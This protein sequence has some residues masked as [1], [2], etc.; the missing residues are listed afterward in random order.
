LCVNATTSLSD[1]VPGGVW[2]SDNLSVATISAS[3]IVSGV[4]GGTAN[5]SYTLGTCAAGVAI[6]VNSLPPITGTPNVCAGMMT[7][8]SDTAPGG[9]WSSGN[10][11]AAT[12]S[13][14]GVVTGIVSGSAT[15]YYTVG[16][17]FVS[18][19]V[20]V[21]YPVAAIT[22]P[23]TVCS[24][25]ALSLSDATSGGVW[26]CD[27]TSVA[28]LSGSGNV[29][30]IA[31]GVVNISYTFGGCAASTSLTVLATNAGTIT[32]KD[33]VC[34]GS[35]HVITLSDAVTGGVWTSSN[36][37]RATV[38][39]VTG[40]VTGVST[41][42]DTIKYTVSNSCGTH[43]AKFVLHVRTA[44][45]CALG[46]DQVSEAPVGGLKLFPD[47]N[48]GI[49]TIELLA[50]IDEEAFVTITNV[51][52][53]KVKEFTTNTNR[54]IEIRLDRVAGIYLVNVSTLHG[55]YFAKIIIN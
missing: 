13:S 32:G 54:S 27:N 28:T 33:S 38:N 11:A 15:I 29:T 41:G 40:V 19:L 3:G 31:P 23:S 35:V 49:F 43:V 7:V 48:S 52:G 21:A 12:V 4:S 2:T 30:G 46:F 8:L 16:A 1:A 26:S 20:T 39:A 36:I 37:A 53:Q 50:D 45:Q 34:M 10:T 24:G 44:M 9:A 55:R 51:V 6:T 17:C 42:I 47:P 5:I 22:G 25:S 14:S 18:T